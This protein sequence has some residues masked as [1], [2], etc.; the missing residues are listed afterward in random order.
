M[1]YTEEFNKL[2]RHFRNQ[3]SDRAKAETFAFKEAFKLGLATFK[4]R[5]PRQQ[6]FKDNFSLEEL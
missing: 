1:P 4:D 2:K 6:I 5:K 3:Y